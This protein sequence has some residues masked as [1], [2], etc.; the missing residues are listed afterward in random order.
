MAGSGRTDLYMAVEAERGRLR[1]RQEKERGE[2]EGCLRKERRV[3]E[4][5]YGVKSRKGSEEESRRE[6][7]KITRMER[8]GQS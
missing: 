6:E 5:N 1:E 3:K 7:G 4:D 2:V 8:R